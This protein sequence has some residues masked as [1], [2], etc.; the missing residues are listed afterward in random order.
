MK[1]IKISD[2]THKQLKVVCATSGEKINE[3]ADKAILTS[4]HETSRRKSKKNMPKL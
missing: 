3:F 1:N 2:D 4:I